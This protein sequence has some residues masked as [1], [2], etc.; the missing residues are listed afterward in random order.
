VKKFE[1]QLEPKWP[2][3]NEKEMKKWRAVAGLNV[4]LGSIVLIVQVIKYTSTLSNIV[5]WV[6]ICCKIHVKQV[7]TLFTLYE[8]VDWIGIG[9]WGGCFMM[10]AGTLTIQRKLVPIIIIFMNHHF[11][12]FQ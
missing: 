11:P 5:C 12:K 1:F 4:I 9:I 2:P 3:L 7:A 6:I 10:S 8:W